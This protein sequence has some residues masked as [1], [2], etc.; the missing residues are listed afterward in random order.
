MS[1]CHFVHQ[2]T[3]WTILGLNTFLRGE[4][5]ATNRLRQGTAK[6]L[7]KQILLKPINFDIIITVL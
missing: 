2:I 1:Q 7:L 4:R 3:I 6:Y 5:L